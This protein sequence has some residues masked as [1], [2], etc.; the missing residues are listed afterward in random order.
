MAFRFIGR[1]QVS[2]VPDSRKASGIGHYILVA[3]DDGD[4]PKLQALGV[5]HGHDSD[6]VTGAW[7]A[8]CF[9]N[10]IA[11]TRQLLFASNEHTNIGV[12]HAICLARSE[13]LS[14][15]LLLFSLIR[16]QSDFRNRPVEDRHRATPPFFDTIHVYNGRR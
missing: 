4:C 10:G 7:I 5:V 11:S 14:Q 8:A 1:F 13:E 12:I 15:R 16:N 3:G 2:H 6:A 9:T